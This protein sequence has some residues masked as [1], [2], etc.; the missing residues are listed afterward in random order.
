[1][2]FRRM[3]N[4]V[5]NIGSTLAVGLD[6][7]VTADGT[8]TLFAA[9]EADAPDQRARDRSVIALAPHRVADIL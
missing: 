6:R 3:T 8:A 4:R 7:F 1:V 2:D 5:E 9:S